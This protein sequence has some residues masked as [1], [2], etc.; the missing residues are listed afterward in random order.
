MKKAHA[1]NKTNP[2]ILDS[3][4]TLFMERK[5]CNYFSKPLTS[6]FRSPFWAKN[7]QEVIFKSKDQDGLGQ[8]LIT[9]IQWP[10]PDFM[11]I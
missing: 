2:V 4:R 6:E 10:S 11:S 9:C 8:D 3:H 7:S 5:K 1:P